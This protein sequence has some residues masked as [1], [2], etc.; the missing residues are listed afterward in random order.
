M[1]ELDLQPGLEIGKLLESIREAQAVGQ[2]GS[3]D[4]AIALARKLHSKP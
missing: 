1:K 3:R 4:E 2:I